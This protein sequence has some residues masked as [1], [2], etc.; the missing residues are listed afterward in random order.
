MANL[1]AGNI[2]LARDIALD[3]IS[4]A[5]SDDFRVNDDLSVT[6]TRRYP[7]QRMDVYQSRKAKAETHHDYIAMRARNLASEDAKVGEELSA[8]ADELQELIPADWRHSRPTIQTVSGGDGDTQLYD[9]DDETDGE[10]GLS[11]E[12][13]AERLRQLRRGR[14]RGVKEVDTEDEIFDLYEEFAKGGTQLPIPDNYYDRRILP[15]GTIIGVRESNDNG[16]TLDVKYPPGVTGPDKVHLPPPVA[17]PPTPPTPGE[18]PIIAPPPHLPVVDHP[19]APG[20]IPPWAQ[21]PAGVPQ[22][23]Y[24]YGG[25]PPGVAVP[26]PEPPASTPSAGPGPGWSPGPITPHLTPEDQVSI[27]SVLFGGL[28]GFLGWLGTPKGSL[29]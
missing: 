17:A 8:G 10:D 13:I 11:A 29:S 16:P 6:D 1:G 26:S 22:G 14:S 19:P 7:A 5:E 27:G 21:A 20:L 15:D 18:A 3:A 2:R 24:P 23:P 25:L 9:S 28:L 12:Q 4:E